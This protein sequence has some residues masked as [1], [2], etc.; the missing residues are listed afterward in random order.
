MF[1]GKIGIWPFTVDTVDQRGSVNRPKGALVLKNI[2]SI[3]KKVC[4]H[5]IIDKCGVE[6]QLGTELSVAAEVPNG[7]KLPGYGLKDSLAI[8]WLISTGS[9]VSE[10]TH[11]VT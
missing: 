8:D 2:E 6:T 11:R 1:N 3:D 10:S 7:D 5:Y 9:D 4:K